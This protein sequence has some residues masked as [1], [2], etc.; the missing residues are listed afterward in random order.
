MDEGS[1]RV[2]CWSFPTTSFTDVVCT[3]ITILV[4]EEEQRSLSLMSLMKVVHVAVV[5]GHRDWISSSIGD[6][7]LG[8]AGMLARAVL[9]VGRS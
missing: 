6:R 4:D 1:A 3:G 5:C 7:R 2:L 8:S 9:G